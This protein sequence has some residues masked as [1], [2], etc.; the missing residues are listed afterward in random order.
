METLWGGTRAL[1]SIAM[2]RGSA[3][4]WATWTMSSALAVKR[5]A[6]SKPWID[7]SEDIT[8]SAD[9]SISFNGW[10]LTE[11]SVSYRAGLTMPALRLVSRAAERNSA[12]PGEGKMRCT[13]SC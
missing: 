12:C 8:K 5:G 2:P 13:R 4:Q 3:I 9:A 7:I 6:M 10:C 11:M 1:T